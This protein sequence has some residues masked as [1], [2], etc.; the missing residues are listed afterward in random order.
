MQETQSPLAAGTHSARPATPGV[1]DLVFVYSGPGLV[2][3]LE[4][5]ALS[6]LEMWFGDGAEATR[7]RRVAVFRD[8][9]GNLDISAFV[10]PLAAV[11]ASW[12]L[13]SPAG[14]IVN[15]GPRR[16]ANGEP[17]P[18]QTREELEA[19]RDATT[20]ESHVG[21][22]A[23]YGTPSTSH[24]APSADETNAVAAPSEDS[25]EGSFRAARG[26]IYR[27]F[28]PDAAE[29]P[30]AAKPA[31]KSSTRADDAGASGSSQ[32]NKV[33]T[34]ARKAGARNADDA[35]LMA[36]FCADTLQYVAGALS[37][38]LVWEGAQHSGLSTSELVS[39]C[40]KDTMAVSDLQWATG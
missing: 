9:D 14:R 18:S 24:R 17:L 15:G 33:L 20:R 6:V 10:S 40:N 31:A 1:G 29:E 35:G 13:V 16:A 38:Q 11:E 8:A 19:F 21:A 25:R 27:W 7:R 22:V 26:G 34:A 3:R 36:L 2:T 5:W 39:L 12:H 4:G 32:Y 28:D 23:V 37:P 30:A